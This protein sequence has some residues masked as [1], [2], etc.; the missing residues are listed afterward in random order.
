MLRHTFPGRRH[1]GELPAVGPASAGILPLKLRRGSSELG[2]ID[3]PPANMSGDPGG[4]LGLRFAPE[5]GAYDFGERYSPHEYGFGGLG[6]FGLQAYQSPFGGMYAGQSTAIPTTWNYEGVPAA[7]P[8]SP[9]G[10][11]YL[12]STGPGNVAQKKP[13]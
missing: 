13:T 1:P 4:S 10:P 12:P 8:I 2:G 3:I 5:G 11:D 6:G 7:V 9:L